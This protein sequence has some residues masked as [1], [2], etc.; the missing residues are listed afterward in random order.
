MNAV[1]ATD[2]PLRDQVA[3]F[4]AYC[5][6][7][8]QR[9]SREGRSMTP[10]ELTQAEVFSKVVRMAFDAAK[11]GEYECDACVFFLR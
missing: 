7:L 9:S 3:A 6:A 11:A 4:Q 5:V 2:L 8:A 10:E 1:Q